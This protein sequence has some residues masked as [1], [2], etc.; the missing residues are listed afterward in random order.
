MAE[1]RFAREMRVKSYL[2]WE[3]MGAGGNDWL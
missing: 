2:A 1:G 3:M